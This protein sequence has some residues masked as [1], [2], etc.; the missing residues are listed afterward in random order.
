MCRRLNFSVN[1]IH[2]KLYDIQKLLIFRIHVEIKQ[3]IEKLKLNCEKLKLNF[4]KKLKQNL[5]KTQKPPTP[6]ELICQKEAL[7]LCFA[8]FYPA[9]PWMHPWGENFFCGNHSHKFLCLQIWDLNH[10]G[11]RHP[12][13]GFFHR[14]SLNSRRIKL[15]FFSKPLNFF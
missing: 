5:R 14:F 7:L 6:V 9:M 2:Y 15:Y 11:W 4:E 13:A 3:M 1:H 12:K 8:L 10:F